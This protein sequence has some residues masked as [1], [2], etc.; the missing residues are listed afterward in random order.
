VAVSRDE[1]E[2]LRPGRRAREGETTVATAVV[3]KAPVADDGPRM[4]S[5]R[6]VIAAF[7]KAAR[8]N[9]LYP[10]HS[11]VRK[12]HV[13]EF[14]G[15]LVR[16]I[17]L[18]GET[19]LRVR[20]TTIAW[21]ETP[22]YVEE[23]R[24]RSL[25]FRLFLNGV[26]R[27]AIEPGVTAA[28]G[29]RF[30]E[31]VTRSFDKEATSDDLRTAVWEAGF[32]TVRFSMT[33][34]LFSPEEES[35]FADYMYA[36]ALAPQTA[37]A[38][39]AR[40]DED[41]AALAALPAASEAVDVATLAADVDA[42]IGRDV[43][44][45]FSAHLFEELG[46]DGGDL[47]CAQLSGF[48]EHVL[49]A[50]EIVRAAR[51]LKALRDLATSSA[52]THRRRLLHEVLERMGETQVIPRIRDDVQ[53]LADGERDA[54]MLLLVAVGPP[55]FA[56]LC[57][58]LETAAK[59]AAID[60]LRVLAPRNPQALLPMLQDARPL[61]VRT[62][63][64]VLAETGWAEAAAGFLPA[65]RHADVGVRREA[66]RALAKLGGRHATEALLA[67]IEDPGYEVRAPALAALGDH[68]DARAVP[69][70]VRRV[71]DPGFLKLT[72]Y[73][74]RET[75]RT[76]ARIGTAEASTALIRIL[77]ATSLLHRSRT[78]EMRALAAAALGI[79]GTQPAR[80]ALE[81]HAKDRS[82][83]VRR[84]VHAALRASA[85]PAAT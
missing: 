8:A 76:L 67:A 51:L 61:V 18:F 49:A 54:L 35:A 78:D 82:D 53:S 73:E 30:V 10:R 20:P 42:E 47:A 27:I 34:E 44:A 16:H 17:E 62:V 28:E 21:G 71:G 74:K 13:A 38:A 81:V 59:S 57:D 52:D 9:Q 69:T 66:V 83:G 1:L 45:E 64:A 22:I 85:K 19:E 32:E 58:L 56:S 2:N 5:A 40:C 26:R 7:L 48:M 12:E 36:G 37:A 33:D 79:I 41:L 75:F 77:Q 3:A 25:A 4:D 68:P 72:N 60:A 43:V 15:K 80:H 29:E 14:A 70:L 6:A 39:R 84:A 23:N 50:G 55:A 24:Q 46:G 11:R 65:V 63:M 31:V